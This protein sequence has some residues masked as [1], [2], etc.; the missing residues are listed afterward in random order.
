MEKYDTYTNDVSEL[1]KGLAAWY[2]VDLHPKTGLC[3]IDLY[4]DWRVLRMSGLVNWI[5]QPV[6]QG[7]GLIIE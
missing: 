2:D 4:R 5:W 6:T 1:I 7:G 3:P